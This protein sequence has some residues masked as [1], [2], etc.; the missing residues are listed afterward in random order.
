MIANGGRVLGITAMGS[1]LASARK[2]AY[3]AVDLIDWPDGFFR[4]DIGLSGLKLV[5]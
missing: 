4:R 5:E 2:L 1:D 3:D